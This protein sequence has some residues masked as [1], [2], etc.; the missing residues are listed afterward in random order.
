MAKSID[1]EWETVHVPQQQDNNEWETVNQPD[2]NYTPQMGIIKDYPESQQPVLQGRV[3]KTNPI[4]DAEKTFV[5]ALTSPVRAVNRFTSPVMN[6]ISSAVT[7]PF[8]AGINSIQG[9]QVPDFGSYYNQNLQDFNKANEDYKPQTFAGKIAGFGGEFLPYSLMGAEKVGANAIIGGGQGLIG[10]I[11]RGDRPLDIAK[12]TG[13]GA[14]IGATGSLGAKGLGAGFEKVQPQVAELM[15]GIRKESSKR[16][17]EAF[18]NGQNLFEGKFNP[19]KS[20]NQIGNTAQKAINFVKTKAG[21]AVN[22]ELESLRNNNPVLFDTNDVSQNIADMLAN[23]NYGGI[24]T[25]DAND[26]NAIKNIQDILDTHGNILSPEQAYGLKKM[27]QNK[28][29]NFD[30][31]QVKLTTNEGD[32]ILNNIGKNINKKLTDNFPEYAKTS[33][34]Y[35]KIM[36]LQNKLGSKLKDQSIGNALRTMDTKSNIANGY[37]EL[38]NQLDNIAPDN[39][40]FMNS[41]KDLNARQDFEQWIPLSHGALGLYAG[42]SAYHG[43]FLPLLLGANAS[44]AIQKLMLQ[45]YFAGQKLTP[46][47]TPAL[48]TGYNQQ[49]NK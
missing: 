26:L 19:A 5:S 32:Y 18:K 25:L 8:K 49:Q 24:Q 33:S 37:P 48:M 47:L 46:A 10:S 11:N 42:N 38:F 45:G 44:L 7:Y 17:L 36:D 40:K 1:N 41:V 22:S 15:S 2:N 13:V 3:E 35:S 29:Q 23:K 30:P 6:G 20:F 43:N 21:K 12:N 34:E 27:I 14:F 9:K 39:L 28:Y 16:V 31:N 4:M